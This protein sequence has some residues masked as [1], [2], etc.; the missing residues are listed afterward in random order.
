MSDKSKYVGRDFYEVFG[1]AKGAP[2][3][4]I[5]RAYRVL[6]LKVHPDRNGNSLESTRDF[7]ELSRMME[8]LND[9]D[10]RALYD[11]IGDADSSDL[12]DQANAYNR[13]RE[14]FRKITEADIDAYA[15]AYIESDEELNDV[16]HAYKRFKGNLTKMLEWIPLSDPNHLPRYEK[17]IASAIADGRATLYPDWN[18]AKLTRRADRHRRKYAGEAE[19]A[20]RLKQ[21]LLDKYKPFIK[22][23]S[24]NIETKQLRD[25][26]AKLSKTTTVSLPEPRG[27]K[28]SKTNKDQHAAKLNPADKRPRFEEVAKGNAKEEQKGAAG[29]E[30]VAFNFE[31]D[32]QIGIGLA[33]GMRA[34]E[35]AR[36]REM[37]RSMEVRYGSKKRNGK[38]RQPDLPSE[39]EFVQIQ[40]RLDQER[41][42]R[43]SRQA[44]TPN[45]SRPS[46]AKTHS[47]ETG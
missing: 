23:D 17:M 2:L 7:Q 38:R 27:N 32:K 41:S 42:A 37:V 15:A 25:G 19:E 35:M 6:A 18:T 44:P 3:R 20:E 9:P 31:D 36:H 12:S 10:R 22:C 34:R 47:N 40:R 8:I 29:G 14:V 45:S 16:L 43:K 1:V 26:S 4:D 24:S 21:D 13:W 28:R 5:Q 39:K 30:L 46:H 33:A 11:S